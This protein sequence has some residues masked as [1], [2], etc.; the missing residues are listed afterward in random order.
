[1]SIGPDTV[2]W[3]T[4]PLG[5]PTDDTV[6]HIGPA[7]ICSFTPMM[8]HFNQRVRSGRA[9]AAANCLSSILFSKIWSTHF[10]TIDSTIFE[11]IGV[12]EIGRIYFS[13]DR[14]GGFLGSGITCAVFH[15]AGI[16]PSRS[17]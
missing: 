16:T 5:F 8:D 2:P 11:T 10:I 1:M 9:H 3:G 15:N 7:S 12:S 13:I 17:Q 14:G 4:P 6:S